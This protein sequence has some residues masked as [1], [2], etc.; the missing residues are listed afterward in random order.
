MISFFMVLYTLMREMMFMICKSTL[1]HLEE[2]GNKKEILDCFK[3]DYSSVNLDDINITFFKSGL[4]IVGNGLNI[5]ISIDDDGYQI[6]KKFD[7]Y[8]CFSYYEADQTLYRKVIRFNYTDKDDFVLEELN[9]D[10]FNVRRMLLTDKTDVNLERESFERE[11]SYNDRFGINEEF[12]KEAKEDGGYHSRKDVI[13]KDNFYTEY[14]DSYRNKVNNDLSF[15]KIDVGCCVKRPSSNFIGRFDQEKDALRGAITINNP[16]IVVVGNHNYYEDNKFSKLDYI[17]TIVN[18]DGTLSIEII[19]VDKNGIPEKDNVELK[20]FCNDKITSSDID[21]VIWLINKIDI[22][23]K[24]YDR[25]TMELKNIKASLM[26]HEGELNN[27][28]DFFIAKMKFIQN[29]DNL[30][31]DIYENMEQYKRWLNQDD[32]LILKR[33]KTSK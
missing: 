11:L 6:T 18:F 16:S 8:N 33:S 15:G 22:M 28:I 19:N 9:F 25:V 24:Y 29:F 2:L 10:N 30:A 7:G 14:S 27:E 5:D 3:I 12:K 17:L 4:S 21:N 1:A 32:T 20:A 31:L 26:V 13:I 23:N